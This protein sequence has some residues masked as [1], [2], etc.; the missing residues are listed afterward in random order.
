MVTECMPMVDVVMFSALEHPSVRTDAGTRS[1]A[2]ICFDSSFC[3]SHRV[4]LGTPY[5]SLSMQV[6]FGTGLLSW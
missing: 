2:L 5:G 1:R 6:G 4:V 3:R